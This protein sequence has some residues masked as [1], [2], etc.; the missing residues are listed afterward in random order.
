MKFKTNLNPAPW[1]L[2]VQYMAYTD[3]LISILNGMTIGLTS[4]GLMSRRISYSIPFS[5]ISYIIFSYAHTYCAHQK[6]IR[7]KI[8][9]KCV[10]PPRDLD[11]RWDRIML[12]VLGMN[13]KTWI[14]SPPIPPLPTP[15][16]RGDN[17]TVYR[18]IFFSNLHWSC[19]NFFMLVQRGGSLGKPKYTRHND[20]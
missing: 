16:P 13:N 5:S 12:K 6:E 8:G 15:P 1:R 18:H 17:A 10:F 14:L 4:S 11:W 3:L 19:L 7:S 20:T 2:T 9:E